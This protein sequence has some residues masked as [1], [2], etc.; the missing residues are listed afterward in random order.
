[1]KRAK[2]ERLCLDLEVGRAGE[3]KMFCDGGLFADGDEERSS[4][5]KGEG[6]GVAG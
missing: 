3:V 4:S 6:V 1:M 5:I 2:I